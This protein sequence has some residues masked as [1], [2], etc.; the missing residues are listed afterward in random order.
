MTF[1]SASIA[2]WMVI[3]ALLGARVAFHDQ[4]SLGAPA[5]YVMAWLKT[6]VG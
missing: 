3:V 5:G 2:F 4:I 6:L 1:K